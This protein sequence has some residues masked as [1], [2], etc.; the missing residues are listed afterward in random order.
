[1]LSGVLDDFLGRLSQAHRARRCE[2]VDVALS[3]Q[4]SKPLMCRVL[5]GLEQPDRILRFGGD[6]WMFWDVQQKKVSL[7]AA[8]QSDAA[9]I[10]QIEIL[11]V[12]PG[13]SQ[14]CIIIMV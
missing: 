11:I 6:P 10:F 1:M 5:H 4:L 12:Q 13:R 3:Q 8:R 9:A 7:E 14:F 2:L